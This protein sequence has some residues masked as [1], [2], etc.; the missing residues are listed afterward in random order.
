MS[1]FFL[2]CEVNSRNL[3]I[4]CCR[5]IL[6]FFYSGKTGFVSKSVLWKS[7][8][9]SGLQTALGDNRAL[10]GIYELKVKLLI[11]VG[12]YYKYGTEGS[13]KGS[14]YPISAVLCFFFFGGGVG[15]IW[16]RGVFTGNIE[17]QMRFWYYQDAWLFRKSE[18]YLKEVCGKLYLC[19]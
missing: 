2:G 10:S 4:I 1:V 12:K 8:C 19:P 3:H 17:R 15:G 5:F 11:S 9:F 14:V 13:W 18:S 7:K 6:L 16:R